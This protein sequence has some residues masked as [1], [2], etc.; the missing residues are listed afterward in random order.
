M[1]SGFQA[2]ATRRKEKRGEN[3][4]VSD[5][6]YP[7][8]KQF[9]KKNNNLELLE[10]ENEENKKYFHQSAENNI[11]GF[12]PANFSSITKIGSG[13]LSPNRLFDIVKWI[14]NKFPNSIMRIESQGDQFITRICGIEITLDPIPV[15]KLIKSIGIFTFKDTLDA[16]ASDFRV[17]WNEIQRAPIGL[18]TV[19]SF[20]VI[21]TGKNFLKVW[22]EKKGIADV[23]EPPSI[24][25][26]EVNEK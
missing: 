1:E 25:I 3:W 22:E 17:I 4:H 12:F 10:L 14:L 7:I 26:V 18:K 16:R 20:Y 2:I 8:L 5:D 11:T 24:E 15:L 19:H 23:P 13:I 21:L 6:L 9:L